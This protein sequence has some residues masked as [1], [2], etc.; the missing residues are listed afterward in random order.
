[1]NS[2]YPNFEECPICGGKIS[3]ERLWHKDSY[4]CPMTELLN[5]ESHN[6]YYFIEETIGI[7]HFNQVKFILK[8]LCIISEGSLFSP[9]ENRNVSFFIINNDEI[10][11]AE[12][13][14]TVQTNLNFIIHFLKKDYSNMT[15]EQIQEMIYTYLALS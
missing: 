12:K 15:K 4:I 7:N 11:P 1:M 9:T 3:F 8:S 10:V 14:I 13:V 6:H 2:F 5:G